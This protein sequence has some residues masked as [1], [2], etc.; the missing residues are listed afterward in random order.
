MVW[1]FKFKRMVYFE[2]DFVCG[3]KQKFKFVLRPMQIS[4]YSSIY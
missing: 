1:T 3:G 2:F 4:S